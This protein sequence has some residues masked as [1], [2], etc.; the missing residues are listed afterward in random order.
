MPQMKMVAEQRKKSLRKHSKLDILAALRK[1][2]GVRSLYLGG[3]I[4]QAT[5]DDWKSWKEKVQGDL[6]EVVCYD[7]YTAFKN[8]YNA[9]S[10]A[11][12][13][14][15]VNKHALYQSDAIIL[16]LSL[17]HPTI[18]TV[19]ELA[20]LSKI[21]TFTESRT[22]FYHEKT[23]QYVFILVDD[24]KKV[25]VY[26][27]EFVNYLTD[28]MGTV[29]NTIIENI[30]PEVTEDVKK[31]NDVE[32]FHDVPIKVTKPDGIDTL[33][34]AHA[35]DAGYDI[36]II[37]DITIKPDEVVDIST[38]L[39]LEMPSTIWGSIVHRSSTFRTHK[40]LVHSGTIDPGFRGELKVCVWN[41]TKQN[42][43]LQKGYR[44]AQVIFMPRIEADIKTVEID[45]LSKSVRGANGF[46]SS[47]K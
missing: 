22:K 18:G 35:D 12:Y 29:I 24:L 5:G 2:M 33:Y 15:N 27:R 38:G 46:G 21:S 45:E 28:D 39:F 34:K 10:G 20:D 16:N 17:N 7:P 8:G 9:N 47:G 32:S 13:I 37:E 42:I 31:V 44:I 3:P 36:A 43:K 1:R 11:S 25:P 30:V 26:L 41:P 6:P 19:F 4:D 14:K 40:L 23:G